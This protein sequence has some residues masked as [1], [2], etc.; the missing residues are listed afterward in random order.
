[1]NIA[2][3]GALTLTCTLS[4]GSKGNEVQALQQLL[5]G[6]HLGHSLSTDGKF[7][8]KTHAALLAFQRK[9]GLKPD[10]VVGP[11]TAKALG[12]HYNGRNS[13]PYLLMGQA[14]NIVAD[15]PPM[16]VLKTVIQNGM[17]HYKA[18][19]AE[20]MRKCGAPQDKI[21]NA[22]GALDDPAYSGFL[23]RLDSA[24]GQSI[25]SDRAMSSAL[26]DLE[27]AFLR[28]GVTTGEIGQYLKKNGGNTAAIGALMERLDVKQISFA[29][30]SMLRGDTSV[31]ITIAKLQL[32]FR[33]L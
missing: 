27:S 22:L 32:A 2:P 10:G 33:V 24:M 3:S 30:A 15:T 14:R 11:K 19:F 20:A 26:M 12:W 7:G 21:N 17:E 31:P 4:L 18:R 1:M 13:R 28:F 9:N 8:R 5:N 29:V 23:S 16:M 25:D 6:A